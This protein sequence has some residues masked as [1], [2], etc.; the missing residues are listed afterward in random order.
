MTTSILV[1]GGSDRRYQGGGLDNLIKNFFVILS[2][3][4]FSIIKLRRCGLTIQSSS[5]LILSRPNL[6][7]IPT[8]RSYWQSQFQSDFD[9]FLIN[10]SKMSIY[11]KKVD[12][13]W[14]FQSLSITFNIKSIYLDI[15]RLFRYSPDT[16]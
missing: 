3:N 6:I 4:T 5:I 8:T 10:R 9:L 11:V 16:I 2:S 14:L 12:L 7:W 13:V 1:L 15:N